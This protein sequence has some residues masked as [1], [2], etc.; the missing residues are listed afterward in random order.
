MADLEADLEVAV[1]NIATIARPRAM[2][3]MGAGN[4]ILIKHHSGTRT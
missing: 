3:R 1:A 2:M 4:F